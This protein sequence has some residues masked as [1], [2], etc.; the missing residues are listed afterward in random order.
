MATMRAMDGTFTFGATEI[1]FKSYSINSTAKTVDVTNN[2]TVGG[3]IERKTLRVTHEIDVSGNHLVGGDEGTGKAVIF[4]LNSVAYPTTD[5]SYEET[6]ETGEVTSGATTAGQTDH[7]AYKADR[8]FTASFW[9]DDTVAFPLAGA[10]EAAVLGTFMTGCTFACSTA[11]LDNVKHDGEIKGDVK[12]SVSGFCNG[13]VTETGLGVTGGTSDTALITFKEGA[14][15]DKSL[16]GTAY[17]V[18]KKITTNIDGA[19]EISYKF[20][21]SGGVTASQAN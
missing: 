8:K 16:T 7:K 17:L 2:N 10:T 12:L 15:L 21:F 5:L 20:L 14:T 18:S 9:G 19:I 11:A 1:P 13:T 6:F 4:S 3:G